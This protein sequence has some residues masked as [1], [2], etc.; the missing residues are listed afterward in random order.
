MDEINI[1]KTSIFVTKLNIN[2]KNILNFCYSYKK[3]TRVL[4]NLG[5]TQS[6]DLNINSPE[7]KDLKYNILKS[8]NE[9]G[10]NIF[11]FN[12][13][14][15]ISNIWFNIN[16][17]KDSNSLHTHPF[18]ILSG[19]FYVKTPKNCGELVFF[20]PVRISSFI[21]NLNF[22]GYNPHNSTD[23]KITP[24]ENILIIFPS[25]LEHYVKPNMS[26]QDRIS[27]SFNLKF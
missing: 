25:W 6:S 11:Q 16:K 9:I 2:L 17:Y 4:S 5:G 26:K 24:Q 12:R 3:D 14:L 20:N 27:F 1:F 8:S 10:K 13:D 22:N 21:E 7:L 23:T 19:V 15:N 18:S